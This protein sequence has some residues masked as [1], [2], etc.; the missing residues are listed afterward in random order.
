MFL[1][2]ER[3]PFGAMMH[4]VFG[5]EAQALPSTIDEYAFTYWFIHQIV[6][7]SYFFRFVERCFTDEVFRRTIPQRLFEKQML[8]LQN[9]NNTDLGFPF[10]SLPDYFKKVLEIDIT[11]IPQTIE[12]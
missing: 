6:F 7:C 10:I 8:I 12:E 9:L 3:T 2:S 4:R 1:P 11:G 5:E